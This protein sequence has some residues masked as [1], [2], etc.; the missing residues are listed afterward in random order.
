M[1]KNIFWLS[2][3]ISLVY[4]SIKIFF[5]SLE[6]VFLTSI[7][8]IFD[9]LILFATFLLAIITFKNDK[10]V[11]IADSSGTLFNRLNL[12]LL[13]I[14]ILIISISVIFNM[15]KKSLD[16]DA[17]A[18]YDSRAKILQSGYKFSD[19]NKLSDYDDKNKYYYL[20][21]PPVT[22]LEHLVWY[23]LEINSPVGLVY[24]IDLFVLALILLLIFSEF[25]GIT[26]ALVAVLLTISNKDIFSTSL[27]EYTNLPFTIFIVTGVMLTLLG[28][29]TD[30]RY[31]YYIGFLL[32]ASSSWVRYLEPVWLCVFVSLLVTTIVLKRFKNMLLPLVLGLVTM[33]SQYLSWGNFQQN[34]ANSPTI[35]N[36]TPLIVLESFT[37][38]FTGAFLNVLIYY[39]SSFGIILI[40]YVVSLIKVNKNEPKEYLF[41]RLVIIIS[42]L[43]YLAGIYG[44]SFMFDWWK[45]MSGSLVRSSSYLVPLSIFLI[46]SNIKYL[47]ENNLNSGKTI[48]VKKI[49]KLLQ[50]DKN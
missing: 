3:F 16:W 5:V 6:P 43:M 44:I 18:L 8:G 12:I 29:K 33:L 23:K 31:Y 24:S 28:L 9:I 15:N 19:M 39:L 21:Y 34:V 10:T 32:I 46:V 30:K 26:G 25:I 48:S 49:Y 17:V 35:F 27:I 42:L 50:N 4:I 22:T 38:V 20:L 45:E 7:I 41:V 40:V 47:L 2:L 1:K 11:S 14:I 37:G 36:L 13:F